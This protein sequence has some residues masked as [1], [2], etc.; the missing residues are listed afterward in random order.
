MDDKTLEVLLFFAIILSPA[1][2][3]LIVYL[4]T[5][6][7]LNQ[8]NAK[9]SKELGNNAALSQENAEMRK[10]YSPIMNIDEYVAKKEKDADEISAQALLTINRAN[11]NAEEII[12]SANDSSESIMLHANETL[13]AANLNANKI[14]NQAHEEAKNIAGDAIKLKQ[15]ADLFKSTA[16]AM[17]NVITG[18]GDE[19]LI[20][21]QSVLDELAEE[22]SHKEAGEQLKN[23]RKKSR[24]MVKSRKAAECDYVENHRKEHAIKFAV[25]AFNGKVDTALSKVKHNNYGKI[26]QEIVDGFSLVNHSGQAFR[27]A[28]ITQE[29]LDARLDELKWAVAAFELQ[30]KEREE[31]REIREQMRE[32]QRAAKEIEKA[33]AEAEKEEKALEKA[34]EKAKQEL[35]AATE[36]ERQKWED[37]LVELQAKLEE[38]EL[39]GQRALSMAQQTRSGHV[40]VISNVGSFGDNIFKIG[41]TRRLEPMD[42][43]KELGDASVPFEFDV[44][45]MIYSEDAPALEKELHRRFDQSSVNKVNPRKEFFNLSLASI[46]QYTDDSGLKDIHW[47]MKAEAREYRESLAI[48]KKQQTTAA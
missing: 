41:M 40:Y 9:L 16:E 22:Y 14:I 42:R 44:H 43:V 48:A 1:V 5:K 34:M 31:Q 27:N 10:K 29:Y 26:K 30:Q 4:S 39:R 33:L 28:R 24:A 17:R 8:A 7:K 2:Y 45:A 25:D 19:Y 13:K 37:Q 12:K 36:A 35:A 23:A 32:E 21:N 46:K 11:K 38:A 6:K 18:Y 20:A 47:T 3:F 15:N